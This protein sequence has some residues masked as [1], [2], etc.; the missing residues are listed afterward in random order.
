MIRPSADLALASCADHIARAVLIRAKERPAA[1]HPLR[2][3]RLRG[4]ER[5]IRALRIP[6]YAAGSG[7]LTVIIRTIPVARPLP[8]IAGHIV[9]AISIRKIL[10]DRSNPWITILRRIVIRKV[11]L[12]CVGHPFSIR[13]ELVAPCEGLAG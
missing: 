10:C 13:T 6:R 1:V 11:A 8:H 2:L 12:V 9:Q 5:G 4:I 3:T 7:Q